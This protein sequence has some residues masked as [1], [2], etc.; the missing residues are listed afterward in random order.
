MR[1]RVGGSLFVFVRRSRV[2]AVSGIA[3][4]LA[5]VSGFVVVLGAFSASAGAAPAAALRAHSAQ[6]PGAGSAQSQCAALGANGGDNFETLAGATTFITSATLTTTGTGAQAATNCTVD[7]YVTPSDTFIVQLPVTGWNGM[8]EANG[9]HGLGGAY[10]LN[11]CAPF[12]GKGYATVANS[13]GH[14]DPAIVH[15]GFAYHNRQARIDFA[16]R[17][18]HVTTVAAKAIIRA[19]YGVGPHESYFSGCSEGGRQGLVE[20][21][22]YPADFN[23]I[24]SGADFPQ[25]SAIIGYDSIYTDVINRDASGHTILTTDKLPILHAAALKACGAVDGTITDPQ[26]CHFDPAVVQCPATNPNGANC[27]SAAQVRVARLFYGPVRNS[28]GQAITPFGSTEPG[29]ELAWTARINDAGGLSLEGGIGLQFDRYMAF[30]RDPGP[31]FQESD[32][33]FNTDPARITSMYNA[34]PKLN[35]F[36]KAGGKLIMWVGWADEAVPPEAMVQFYKA[37]EARNGGASA[38]HSFVRL[39]MIPGENHCGGG[40]GP[41][42]VSADF[43]DL[44]N[45]WVTT[46]QAPRRAVAVQQNAAGQTT[47]TRAI[48]PYPLLPGPQINLG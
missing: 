27:L 47:A 43:A 14:V 37:I 10:F 7:G 12:L 38:T 9:S 22:R 13:L 29:S 8:M 26:K 20:A 15:G 3:A 41:Q 23:G 28:R 32:F 36:R 30:P 25:W 40:S 4:I 42:L 44:L 17:A 35:A 16:Y 33:N 39:F 24:I 46:G 31:T 2:F 48:R 21:E 45:K 5:L 18:T 1:V 6:A 19:F 34:N 11:E